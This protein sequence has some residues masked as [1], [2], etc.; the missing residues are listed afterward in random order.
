M[1]LGAAVA[2]RDGFDTE[3]QFRILNP[4]GTVDADGAP[5]GDG[6]ALII[7][8]QGPTATGPF[9]GYIP[10]SI[11]NAVALEFDTW[12]NSNL[13]DPDG[14]HLSLQDVGPTP[15]G[16]AEF[17]HSRSLGWSAAGFNLSD[18][19]VHTAHVRYRPGLL[20]V[21][22]DG[23]ATPTLVATLDLSNIG[24][25]S[26]L[27]VDGSAWLSFAAGTGAAYEGHEILNWSFQAV[28]PVVNQPPVA[29]A[30]GPYTLDAGSSLTLNGSGTDP[31]AGDSLT[32]AWDLNNDGTYGDASGAT[33][34]LSTAA[35]VALG[36]G[37][38]A[39]TIFLRVTD[40]AGASTTVSSALTIR[41]TQTI[42]LNPIADHVFGDAPFTISATASS[43]LPVTFTSLTPSVATVS[44]N[45][46]TLVGAGTAT[47]RASQGG[48]ANWQPAPDAERTFTVRN[49]SGVWAWG[50]G[51]SGQLGNGQTGNSTVPGAVWAPP[52]WYGRRV[53]SVAAGLSHCLALLDDGGVWA[54]GNGA[55]G[56][57]GNGRTLDWSTPM[58]VINPVGWTG[59]KVVSVAAG[60]SHSL[61]LL[62]DGSIWAWGDG[63]AGQLGNGQ[64]GR[65]Y[66]SNL[67]VAVSAPVEWI[68]R[69]VLNI[70]AGG[71][72]SLALL[73]DG[74]VWAWGHGGSGELGNGQ[75]VDSSVPVPVSVPAEWNGHRVLGVAAGSNHSLALVDDGS[76][77][78]WGWGLFGSLGNGQ[79]GV[80]SLPVAV[81]APPAW[82]GRRV[83]SVAAGDYH[84]LA[85]LDD[86]TTWAWG[87]DMSGQLGNGQT[88]ESSVP[89]AVST[90][91]EWNGRRV[92]GVAAGSSHSLAILDDGSLWSWGEGLDG[93][94][95]D[96]R[97]LSS[98]SPVA[99][100]APAAWTGYRV[101]SVTAGANYNLALL[102]ELNTAPTV[103]NPV[104]SQ[105]ATYGTPFAFLVPANTF[106]DPDAGQAL[107]Y[108][109]SGLPAWLAFD[110][111]TRTFSGTP[112][113][114]GSFTLTVT[115]TDDGTPAL[116]A[117]TTFDLV[118]GKAPL[119]AT[120]DTL[121]RFYGEENPPLTGTL[122]GVVN[123]D[124]ITA[125]Y[126]TTAT[127]PGAAGVYT[128]FVTLNDPD[129]RLGN[130]EVTLVTGAL[131]VE[132][133]PQT[134]T[135]GPIP[136]HV[137]GDAPFTVPVSASSGL[138]V[139][140]TSSAASVATG[141]GTT[142]TIAGAGT[143]LLT[144]YQ[145][146]DG[147]YQ[148]AAFVQVSYTVGKATPVITW[149]TPAP[150]TSSTPLSAAQLNA[151]ANTPGS[152]AYAPATGTTLPRGTHVLSAEFTPGDAANYTT[153]SATVSLEVLN[154]APVATGQSVTIAEDTAG[155]I[156]LAGTDADADALSY[157][158]VSGPT[159]G[160]LS[161]M[162][163]NLTY[164]PAANYH[165]AD[166]FT[167][168]VNDGTVDS[169]VTTVAV[170][171]TAVNDTPV[172]TDDAYSTDEDTVLAI[173]S[174]GLLGNDTDADAGAM[175]RFTFAG[176]VRFADADFTAGERFVGFY[177]L[178]PAAVPLAHPDPTLTYQYLSQN[179]EWEIS[180]PD[181]GY[182]FVA[183][184]G[185]TWISVGNDRPAW[186]DRY[187]ASLASPASVGAPLPSGRVLNMAQLD[188][189]DHALFG[190][191]FLDDDSI[192]TTSIRLSAA[193]NRGGRFAF[194]DGSQPPLEIDELVG[195]FTVTRVNGQ[196]ADVNRAFALPSGALLRVNGNGSF[197]YDPNGQFNHL[198]AGE[199][200]TD[201]FTYD[202]SDPDGGS[203]T[204]TT[205]IS[206][207]GVNDAPVA[208]AGADQQVVAGTD[209]MATVTVD[210]SASSDPDGDALSFASELR[211]SG[212]V[213]GA[214]TGQA[215][216]SWSLPPGT[217]E[218]VLTVSTDKNGTVVSR[219]DSLTIQV[220]ASAPA[221][222]ALNPAAAYAG[223]PAFNLTVTGGCFL[224]GAV[225]HWNGQPRTTTVVS[226]S[227]LTAAI[228]TSDLQT[229]V[230]IA[231][232]SI[233]VING[234]GQVSSAQ[235]FS[236]VPRTVGTT[237]SAI[238]L[239]G[240]L[241]QVS[242]P[243][244]DTGTP[245]VAVAFQNTGGQPAS[246]L[247]ATYDRKPVGDTA[248]QVGQGDFVDV[249][250]AG[251]DSQ[252]VAA[253]HFY[254]A[255]TITGNQEV[256]LKLRYFTGSRWVAVRSSGGALP[257]KSTTDNLD[258]TVS[259]GR[260]AVTFDNT[261]TPRITELNGTVFG[262][263]DATPQITAVTGPT[264]PLALGTAATVTLDYATA[265]DAAPPFIRFDWDDGSSSAGQPVG[266]GH[267]AA[268]HH[269]ASAGVYTVIVTVIDPEG[270]EATS[271]FE[272]VV[273][274]DPGAGFVTGLGWLQSPAGA[275]AP[276]PGMTGTALFGFASKYQRGILV[277]I[278]VTEFYV[279]A[280]RFNFLSTSYDWL[281]VKGPRAQYRGTGRINGQGSYGFILT[282][283]D[284]Q[285]PQGGGTDRL[286]LKIWDKTTGH[287]IYD[288][289]RGVTDD[290]DGADPQAIGGGS[291]VIQKG[292]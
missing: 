62:D 272:Y 52:T 97:S 144:A 120:G 147:N 59:H 54:W 126:S 68:G 131:R 286:R 119:T 43:G 22:L 259:G 93:Q 290:V 194:R 149:A 224:P 4:S 245:G 251:A 65:F 138:P 158:V 89:V 255:S 11:P 150:I 159:H 240:D 134:I 7:Q 66:S 228:P 276:D 46:V 236:I 74:S 173:A 106:A 237:D 81:S 257:L 128:I 116:T 121:Y 181:R 91:A 186:G 244:E 171:V 216:A 213:T 51:D 86:G 204:A 172:A 118:V 87:S 262:M 258:G 241:V 261:S 198:A 32:F 221:L 188:L 78:A 16:L 101:V 208:V 197:R 58:A 30:G 277:P 225:V 105:V 112:T 124:N 53:L 77:W 148:A 285:S 214:A 99:V 278:G 107:S 287:V 239:P 37:N 155:P 168:Q 38:G 64:A 176:R 157:S 79:V 92:V 71:F 111:N 185:N 27:L 273:V 137:V 180:F 207:T 203:A 8:G 265:S 129:S 179:A 96:D 103:A 10:Y 284:G 220:L 84:S 21:F 218:A 212:Q 270:A 227:E 165:G 75:L 94:L 238:A 169:A 9:V 13:S 115:A 6:F 5:G 26:P 223:G 229:G 263:F 246:V 232:A 253:V 14:N 288:N 154:S 156:T 175:V 36:L 60:R 142:L 162:A 122:V 19:A 127:P 247:T 199:S 201:S 12:R 41:G 291:I 133:A 269:F 35:L 210:G 192:Q 113:G 193:S 217:Y 282:A 267:V 153:V 39:H 17:Y 23:A 195:P 95:G 72:N 143:T 85:V 114:L 139:T 98:L 69:K 44:G 164:T 1:I 256:K 70:A 100:A 145:P 187:I 33:P 15:N 231:V 2:L 160:T 206:I 104:P 189:D 3:F 234:D 250:L 49:E 163:P 56:Q 55:Y 29:N 202:V 274:Y 152:F 28:V 83:V 61:A 136:P 242:T 279:N 283:T 170:T 235:A 260:F 151:T 130:Y 252:D 45:T 289:R 132:R 243:P 123:G 233:Q 183:S 184:Q 63:S 117:S 167:F 222:T 108:S 264:A 76:V 88:G 47:L 211:Q 57:L 205:I 110:A 50:N 31:D 67:P 191:D 141:S 90:P 177:T 219:S 230:D 25:R 275:Y 82:A 24:G 280:A 271:K 102:G 178:N 42:A 125:S 292:K 182:R 40:T 20:Q 249:Q 18:G 34:T 248:F 135:F 140:L 166:S 215:V 73:D 266:E 209:C 174:P 200:A 281:V 196:A 109:A 190:A 146:G 226:S 48:D 268:N 161:G 254:Y 80:S